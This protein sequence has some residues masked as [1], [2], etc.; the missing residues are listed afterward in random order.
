MRAFYFHLLEHLD[1]LTGI[2]QFDR[3]QANG[4]KDVKEL[5]DILCQISNQFDFIPEKDQEAII[6]A[7]VLAEPDFTGLNARVIYKWLNAQKDRFLFTNTAKINED[8]NWQPLTGE[9][10]DKRLQ[11]FADAVAKLKTHVTPNP[12]KAAAKLDQLYKK[13]GQE[14]SHRELTADEITEKQLHFAWIKANFDARTGKKLDT[15]VEEK[16]WIKQQTP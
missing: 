10:R 11:E 3:L 7:A 1:K 8:P 5:L 15:F 14:E 12:E 13:T 2:K 6:S 4:T 9:A 16:E